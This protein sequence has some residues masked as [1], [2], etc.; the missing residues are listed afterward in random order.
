MFRNKLNTAPNQTL[1]RTRI[2]KRK[3]IRITQKQ[4]AKAR[5][6]SDSLIERLSEDIKTESP[7]MG[8]IQKKLFPEKLLRSH[9]ML[10]P[11]LNL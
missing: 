1:L 9:A 2:K 3:R 4:T 6:K 8:K 5:D 11:A 10:K 7:F